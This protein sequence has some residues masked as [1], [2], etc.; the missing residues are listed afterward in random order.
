MNEKYASQLY[1][2]NHIPAPSLSYLQPESQ[3]ST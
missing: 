1:G 3:P 2:V